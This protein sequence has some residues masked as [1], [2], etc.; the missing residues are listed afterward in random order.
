MLD[1]VKRRRNTNLSAKNVV[2]NQELRRYLKIKKEGK[3]KLVKVEISNGLKGI[4]KGS[5]TN[6]AFP[7]RPSRKKFFSL[8]TL[9]AF[10]SPS[11]EEEEVIKADI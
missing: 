1:R 3:E 5:A 4:L 11:Q 7:L 10:G 6:A 2:Y 9:D 8:N